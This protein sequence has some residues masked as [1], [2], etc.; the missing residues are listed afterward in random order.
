MSPSFQ[1]SIIESIAQRPP[2][3]QLLLKPGQEKGAA[4]SDHHRNRRDGTTGSPL[5][6]AKLA[7]LA[8]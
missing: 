2:T 7:R 6:A 3:I 1:S 5:R 8:P 4:W